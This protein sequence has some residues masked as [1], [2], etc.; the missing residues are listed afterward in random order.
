MKNV[1][2]YSSAVWVYIVII[3]I[4]ISVTGSLRYLF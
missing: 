3:I 1:S 2:N 4:L